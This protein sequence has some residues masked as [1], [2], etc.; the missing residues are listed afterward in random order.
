M[1][2]DGLKKDVTVI[3]SAQSKVVEAP[4][5]QV[6]EVAPVMAATPLSTD[7]ATLKR[8]EEASASISKL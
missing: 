6:V 4:A 2:I 5:K 3:Q 8:L 7:S 1:A